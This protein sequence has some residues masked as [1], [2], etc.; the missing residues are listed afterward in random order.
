MSKFIKVSKV[1]AIQEK[2]VLFIQRSV[3][4]LG[5]YVC[6]LRG[7]R[8]KS[9]HTFEEAVALFKNVIRLSSTCAVNRNYL[10]GVA[11]NPTTL[12]TDVG[13]L[14][15]TKVVSDYGFKETVALLNAGLDG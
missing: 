15:G 11:F 7:T 8:S 13:L 12:K 14:G 2:E 10:M 1:M 3:E 5:V 9:D 6:T 4:P